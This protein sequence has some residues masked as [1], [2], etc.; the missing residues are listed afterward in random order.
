MKKKV[1][2]SIGSNIGNREV[3]ILKSLIK[4]EKIDSIEIINVSS[5]YE[6][7][8]V[9]FTEQD[10]F[11]NCAVEINTILKPY[12]LLKVLKEIE[13]NLGREMLFRWGPRNIDLDIIFYENLKI[14]SDILQIPHKEYT[15]RNFVLIPIFEMCKKKEVVKYLKR[16]QGY[17]GIKKEKKIV[18]ISSCLLG[19]NTKYNGG[20]NYNRLFKILNKNFIFVPICPEQIGGL[21]TP[22]I[23]SE[24][25]GE[26]VRD[27]SGKDVSTEF[28]K[29]AEET[30]KIMRITNADCVVLKSRSP[31]CGYGEIYDGSFSGI[32]KKGNGITA[33][34][35][36]KNGIEIIEF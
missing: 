24:I 5:F 6:T 8:P 20:N 14:K 23:A 29:G 18:G 1:Y 34:L 28:K 17:I 7:E 26:K 3:N 22:R 35:L 12:E 31:S 27:K 10:I 25:F 19:I 33:D 21:P 16:G 30:I 2:I 32:V 13:V 36:E 11:V 4:L 9:G 15:N